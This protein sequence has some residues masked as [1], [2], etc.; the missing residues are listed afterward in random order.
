MT[1]RGAIERTYWDRCSVYRM[2]QRKDEE[3]RQ[4]I[5]SERQIKEGIPCALSQSRSGVHEM[6]DF[7]GRVKSSHTLFCAPETPVIAGDR[8]EIHTSAGQ[9]F[10]LWAG[11]GF[12]YPSHAEIPLSTERPV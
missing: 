2:Q 5:Q 6:A 4:T 3:T 8:L 9:Q 1:E 12:H 11:D 7:H 10:T